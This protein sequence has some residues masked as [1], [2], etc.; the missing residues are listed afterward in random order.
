MTARIGR[1]CYHHYKPFF[2]MCQFIIYNIF[3][4]IYNTFFISNLLKAVR[5][6]DAGI[7]AALRTLDV[8]PFI[9]I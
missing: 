2:I 3:S 1:S 5:P 7:R 6:K 9:R 4:T 8:R